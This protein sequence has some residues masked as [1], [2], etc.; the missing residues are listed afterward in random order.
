MDS[1]RLL[2]RCAPAVIACGVM[3]T[4]SGV[5]AQD[6]E[7][8][9]YTLEDLGGVF[10]RI[11]V[12]DVCQGAGVVA[13]A[14]EAETSVRLIE[15]EVG[16]LT[17]SEMLAQPGLPELRVSLE[18]ASGSGRL[19]DAM[20]YAVGLRVQQAAQMLRDTQITLP[21][22]VTWYSTRL[23]VVAAGEATA[24]IE[25]TLAEAVAEFAVAWA[26]AHAVEGS[27]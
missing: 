10:V 17:R 22:S 12:N 4:P 18:C 27:R 19:A 9:R 25:A 16:V 3:A 21:E 11:E 15:A 5:S 6:T 2:K 20:A 1:M 13:S 23:G 7:W 8:N 26:E 24:A 14:F